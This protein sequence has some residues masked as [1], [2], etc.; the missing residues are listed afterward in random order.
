MPRMPTAELPPGAAWEHRD[1]RRGFEVAFLQAGEEGVRV[2]GHSTAVEEGE[3]FAVQY[4]I[5]LDGRGITRSARVLGRSRL[6]SFERLLESDG[7]G[8]WRLDGAAAPHLDGL[9][10]VDL[11]SSSLTNA[12]PVR[13]LALAVGA[14]ADAPAV[15]VRAL[16]LRVERLEQRYR[17]IDDDGARARYDYE[18]PAF[19]TRCVI[20]YD[21]YGLALDYPGIAIRVA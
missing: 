13:R 14:A 7:A 4:V 11:E 6:G 16:D 12:F 18:A 2:E 8:R 10:D 19:D 21:Q 20:V 17:R 5:A 9:L 15:Y 3:L 1:A